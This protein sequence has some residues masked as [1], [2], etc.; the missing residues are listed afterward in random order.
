MSTA[1][2]LEQ[3]LRK[4]ANDRIQ[5]AA[6]RRGSARVGANL[7]NEDRKAA[8]AL[9]EQM[10]GRKLPKMSRAAEERS[11]IIE[12][13]IASKLEQ[14]AKMLLRFAGFV[15]SLPSEVGCI[16]LVKSE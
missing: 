10:M 8:H 3:W 14:E 9:A 4:E 5:K 7:T 15:A 1:A 16:S 13:R 12:E 2:E 6:A 11:A